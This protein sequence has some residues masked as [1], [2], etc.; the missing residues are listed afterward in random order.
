MTVGPKVSYAA[1]LEKSMK[2]A[3]QLHEH[4]G[5]YYRKWRTAMKRALASRRPRRRG[6][7]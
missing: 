5:Y 7:P 6:A 4:K 2:A 1:S 3:K